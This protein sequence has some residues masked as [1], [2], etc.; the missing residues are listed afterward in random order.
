VWGV[1]ARGSS[2]C[3]VVGGR[4]VTPKACDATICLAAGRA[5]MG[6]VMVSGAVLMEGLAVAGGGGAVHGGG[7]G[8]GVASTFQQHSQGSVA[9]AAVQ[10]L[11]T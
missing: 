4:R 6:A 7:R 11:W 1:V 10:R 9:A 3:M 8:E 5:R 2:G